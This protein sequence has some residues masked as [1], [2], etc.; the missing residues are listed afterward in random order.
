LQDVF[1]SINWGALQQQVTNQEAYDRAR[2]SIDRQ[3][4][5]HRVD[6]PTTD[7]ERSQIGGRS[8][9]SIFNA[10]TSHWTTQGSQLSTN[11]LP[12]THRGRTQGG[13]SEP[14][15]WWSNRSGNRWANVGANRNGQ[16]LSNFARDTIDD[17][18]DANNGLFDATTDIARQ[19]AGRGVSG[20]N[21]WAALDGDEKRKLVNQERRNSHK[22]DWRTH[23]RKLQHGNAG[24]MGGGSKRKL[25][26]A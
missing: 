5:D 16:A 6:A 4:A 26:G 20:D 3:D 22:K 12:Y 15:A 25:R 23:A 11:N 7:I 17:Q 14:N 21:P 1:G 8:A 18:D 2:A 10:G 13:S 24:T 19:V 9:S